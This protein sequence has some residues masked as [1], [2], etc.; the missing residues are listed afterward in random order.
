MLLDII[1]QQ[2][3][4]GSYS[5]FVI[6]NYWSETSIQADM[7]I[8]D[9][10]RGMFS[11]I[12][13]TVECFYSGERFDHPRLVVRVDYGEGYDDYSYFDALDLWNYLSTHPDQYSLGS[14]SEKVFENVPPI[15]DETVEDDYYQT[16]RVKD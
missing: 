16:C 4:N 9:L 11:E 8:F 2:E 14:L 6:H 10:I 1:K 3:S 5:I 13:M 15:E 12:Q 7:A